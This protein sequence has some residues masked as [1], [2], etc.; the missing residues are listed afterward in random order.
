VGGRVR[1]QP[2]G[3]FGGEGSWSCFPSRQ[4][5]RLVSLAPG[6]LEQR[7]DLYVTAKKAGGFGKAA[8][9]ETRMREAWKASAALTGLPLS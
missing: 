5:M 7:T 9:D 8:L 1:A 2:L 6:G 3:A 4:A